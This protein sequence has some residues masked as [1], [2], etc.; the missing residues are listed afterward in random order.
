VRTPPPLWYVEARVLNVE[1]R[2]G[3]N[4]PEHEVYTAAGTTQV[5]DFSDGLRTAELRLGFWQATDQAGI[6]WWLVPSWTEA[7]AEA[8]A[9]LLLQSRHARQADFDIAHNAIRDGLVPALA[10]L[11]DVDPAAHV[12]RHIQVNLMPI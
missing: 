1:F 10:P 5:R 12:P 3:M 4:A 2:H 6:C 8:Q 11:L 7:G 9:K